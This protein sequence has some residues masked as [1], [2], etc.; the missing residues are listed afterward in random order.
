[1][2]LKALKTFSTGG[3][4][5]IKQGDTFT[6][7]DKDAHEYMRLELATEI[8][9]EIPKEV[10]AQIDPIALDPVKTDYT[11]EELQEKNLTDLRKIAKTIG[12]TGYSSMT[13]SE[14]IFAIRAKQ[15]TMEA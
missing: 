6:A 13:K 14:V 8:G 4:K 10:Q 9:G 2:E 7:S 5:L 3:S 12:V 1:M 15:N 11:E